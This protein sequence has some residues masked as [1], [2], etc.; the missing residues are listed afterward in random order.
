MST[1]IIV[2][3]VVLVAGFIVLAW[4]M[5]RQ[6]N[7]TFSAK[8]LDEMKRDIEQIRGEL[9]GSLEKSLEFVQKQ[10]GH[11]HKIVTEVTSKLERLEATNKQVIDFTDNL[12]NLQQ[13]LTNPKHRGVLGEYYLE[14][15]LQNVLPVKN[16]RMQYKFKDGEA[17]DAV[18][19][20]GE[21]IIPVD[22]KFSLENYNRLRQE[23]DAG[24]RQQLEAQFK[25]DLKLRIDET[26]K[27]IRPSE[28]TFDFAFMFIPAEGIYYDLLVSQVGAIKVSTKDLLEYAFEKKVLIVSPNSFYAYL[29]TVLQG[30][31]ALAI[32]ESAKEIREN[33]EKLSKHLQ[34]YELYMQKL[35]SSLGTSVNMYNQA[36]KEFGKVDKDVLK[37]SE[38]GGKV[39]P[40]T[41]D[42]P[43][44][45]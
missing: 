22:S 16:Y 28:K 12:K 37:I 9:K 7:S 23:S 1:E 26:S 10:T 39:E 5:L 40:I 27:Y 13:V 21:K 44:L 31:R 17:V 38:A 42:K 11:S 4:L 45:E 32:E 8:I 20:V 41:L 29:Q 25:Q 36:Y 34:S 24:K 15:L 43:R 6:K 33:V 18:I 14:T 19:F 2:I 35:G 30:L 3:L